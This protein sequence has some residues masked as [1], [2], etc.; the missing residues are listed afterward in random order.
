MKAIG[1][2][3]ARYASTRLKAKV[4]VDLLGKPL[5]QHVW[6]RAHQAKHLDGLFI[7]TDD[8]RIRSVCEGFGA[9][10]LMTS[11][12]CPSGSDRI[13][14]A[15]K[16]INAAYILNIQGDEPLIDASIIDNLIMTLWKEKQAPVATV[17]KRIDKEEDLVNPSVVKV[18]IDKKGYALYF[19]RSVIPFNRE[20]AAFNTCVYYK[21]LGIYGY[22]KSFLMSF[23]KLP[24]SMLEETEKLEQLRVLEAGYKIRVIETNK[25]TISV[26]TAQD[27][28]KVKSYLRKLKK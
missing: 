6:E 15:V 16:D 22:H 14:E 3:P 23:Q 20:T 19:S 10:V 7:A 17:I 12:E 13:I 2:I 28:E 18:V 4:L 1:V 25:E 8:E 5:I 9:K 24:K 26:D 11:P 21:H 27:L